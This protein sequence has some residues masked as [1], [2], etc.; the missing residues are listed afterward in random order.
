[1]HRLCHLGSVSAQVSC[2][3]SHHRSQLRSPVA[4]KT[5]TH[6]FVCA[7]RPRAPRPART[8]G[9]RTRRRRRR[10][11]PDSR[12]PAPRAAMSYWARTVDPSF[13]TPEPNFEP[14]RAEL[15]AGPPPDSPSRGLCTSVA[16]RGCRFVGVLL[17][18][19]IVWVIAAHFWSL[20]HRKTAASEET[21]GLQQ[22]GF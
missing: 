6:R 17:L 13:G 15:V 14:I 9:A 19:L 22:V 7:D 4:T 10:R 11:L 8:G 18:V 1:M 12:R 16:V 3:P 5:N 21:S 2:S 20:H